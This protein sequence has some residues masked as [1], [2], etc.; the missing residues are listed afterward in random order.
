MKMQM[1]CSALLS[2]GYLLTRAF[3]ALNVSRSLGAKSGVITS[4]AGSDVNMR[5]LG[6]TQ[7]ATDTLAGVIRQALGLTAALK[8]IVINFATGKAVVTADGDAAPTPSNDRGYF[9]KDDA[10]K[11]SSSWTWIPGADEDPDFNAQMEALVAARKPSMSVESLTNALEDADADVAGATRLADTR[12]VLTYQQSEGLL[13]ASQVASATAVAY[14][15]A[16]QY[17]E[18]ATFLRT[19]VAAGATQFGE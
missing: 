12:I 19:L 7:P 11:A 15:P 9:A 10:T 18:D 17:G 8:R 4:P 3:T 2:L 6:D 5:T 1:I 13:R 16:A 14:D